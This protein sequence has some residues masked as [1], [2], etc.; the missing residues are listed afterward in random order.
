MA[1]VDVDLESLKPMG[2]I[3]FRGSLSNLYNGIPPAWEEMGSGIS[4]GRGCYLKNNQ[5]HWL[6]S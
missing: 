6:A 2:F 1:E 3:H 4:P 5:W